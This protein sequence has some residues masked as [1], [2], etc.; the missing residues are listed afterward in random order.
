VLHPLH[1]ALEG[2]WS[3]RVSGNWRLTFRF[4]GVDAEIIDLA[5]TRKKKRTKVKPLVPAY[6]R[7]LDHAA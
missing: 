5:Q 4:D 6:K 1:G 2:H 7:P 3:I